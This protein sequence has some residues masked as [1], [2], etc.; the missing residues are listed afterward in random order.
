MTDFKILKGTNEA[1]ILVNVQNITCVHQESKN[2]CKVFF[3]GG[4]DDYINVLGTLE[5]VSFTLVGKYFAL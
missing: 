1:P 5:E 2:T 4:T 3:T